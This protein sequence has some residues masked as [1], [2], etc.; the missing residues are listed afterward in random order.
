M[1]RF[2]VAAVLHTVLGDI[3]ILNLQLVCI[4]GRKRKTIAALKGA[5]SRLKV[6]AC[7]R[8]FCKQAAIC[9]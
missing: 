5:F 2:Y 8:P 7:W 6:I 3:K 1:R 9:G 4:Y